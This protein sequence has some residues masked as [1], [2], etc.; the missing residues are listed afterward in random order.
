MSRE[1]NEQAVKE[2]I[3]SLY[4][5]AGI[6]PVW[7]GEINDEVA[8][9][10]MKMLAAT[11]DCSHAFIWVPQPPGGRATVA[12]LAMNLG[13]S[14][15]AMSR[16]KLSQTCARTVIYEWRTALDLASQGLALSSP[17]KQT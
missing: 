9:I 11:K 8:T 6:L 15:L 2:I 13:R 1:Q 12:W 16:E 7:N 17:W 3:Q 4:R 5:V 14:A 10:V